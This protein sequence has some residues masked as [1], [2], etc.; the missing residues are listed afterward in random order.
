MDS[1]DLVTVYTLTDPVRA[2]VIR[3]AL[4]AEGIHCFLDG[5]NAAESTGISAFEIKVQV[6]AG[7][8]DRAGRFIKSHEARRHSS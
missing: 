7:D 3:G 8:A 2:E 1:R 4:Q 5:L 6:P